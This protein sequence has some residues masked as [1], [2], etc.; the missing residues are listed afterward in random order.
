MQIAFD[1]QY[2]YF[3]ALY[4][5]QEFS[6]IRRFLSVQLNNELEKLRVW[7]VFYNFV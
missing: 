6:V 2:K 1:L 3:W 4:E 5:V 7:L